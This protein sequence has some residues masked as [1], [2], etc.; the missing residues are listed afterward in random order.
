MGSSSSIAEGGESACVLEVRDA[1]DKADS[2]HLEAVRRLQ[3]L[4]QL[5]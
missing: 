3:Q 2:Q 1:P 5:S 4:G